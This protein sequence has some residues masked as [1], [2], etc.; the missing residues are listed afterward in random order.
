MDSNFKMHG[1]FYWLVKI[2]QTKTVRRGEGGYQN[3]KTIGE[4]Q[5]GG[6]YSI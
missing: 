2:K 5:G 3:R 4:A 6:Y 1:N